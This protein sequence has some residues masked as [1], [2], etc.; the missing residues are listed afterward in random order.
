MNKKVMG[1]AGYFGKI[2]LMLART[3]SVS[4][5]VS[6]CNTKHLV[7]YNIK[8]KKVLDKLDGK[9]F[10]LNEDD[11]LKL[12][13]PSKYKNL[14]GQKILVRSPITCTC[15]DK[16][17]SRC[18]GM[19]AVINADIADGYSAFDSEEIT[20]VINQS[21]LSTKHLLTTNSEVIEFSPEFN[22]F[23]TIVGGEIYPI[24]NNNT[25][26]DDINN[27]AIYIDPNDKEKVDEMDDD[28]AYNT[29]IYNGRIYIRDLEHP[30]KEDILIQSTPEKEIFITDEAIEAMRKHR[31]LIYFKD[32]D[33]DT[34]LFEMSILNNE[35]TKPLYELMNLLNKEKKDSI[36]ETIDSISEKFL[37]LLIQSKID[38]NAVAAELIINRL[39]RDVDDIYAR[40]DF[41]KEEMPQY[42]IYTVSRALERNKSPLIGISFQNI[43]RQFLSDELYEDRDGTSYID[44]FYRTEISTSNLKNYAKLI[45]TN[46]IAKRFVKR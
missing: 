12:L 28:S 18:V 27:F 6:D 20:K 42:K 31:G 38:A 10:K 8:N 9:Y 43:K 3:L 39:L 4:T 41:S 40:P 30:G 7:E 26:V 14:I 13:I 36:N 15:G 37:D 11:E 19:A 45:K 2:V 17:C 5:E 29:M 33:D 24:V 44:E 22:N 35:L 32:L 23:F 34:K 16:V 1:R 21:I 46:D 25:S